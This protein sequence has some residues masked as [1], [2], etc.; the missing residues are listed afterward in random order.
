M[1]TAA[2]VK[3]EAA[4]RISLYWRNLCSIEGVAAAGIAA[5]P[6]VAAARATA[7]VAAAAPAGV[8]PARGGGGPQETIRPSRGGA[9]LCESSVLVILCVSWAESSC[10]TESR[11]EKNKKKQDSVKI[12]PAYALAPFS[13]GQYMDRP[14][15]R[16]VKST[17]RPA[18]CRVDPYRVRISWAMLP[19]DG[20][21][22]PEA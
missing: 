3:W 22:R 8:A 6:G 7:V 5:A 19:C 10:P 13:T 2:A 18:Y 16:P 9:E 12:T 11:Q 1:R 20:P 15:A 21:G 4:G 17:D 14:M